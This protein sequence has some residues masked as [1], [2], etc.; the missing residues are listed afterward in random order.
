MKTEPL[1]RMAIDTSGLLSLRTRTLHRLRCRRELLTPQEFAFLMHMDE[2]LAT[3]T[4]ISVKQ[5]SWLI[6]ILDRT[7]TK[8]IKRRA[9]GAGKI[10]KLATEHET[11]R[12]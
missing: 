7:E 3:K 8:A 2:W 9:M 6:A 12:V 1:D 4:W 11:D 5:G 10:K